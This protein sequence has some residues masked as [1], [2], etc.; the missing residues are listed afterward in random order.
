[1]RQKLKLLGGRLR[2]ARLGRK[3]PLRVIAGRVGVSI[4][5]LHEYENGSIEP[6][7]LRLFRL[8][9]VLNLSLNQLARETRRAA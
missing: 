6:P 7:A 2:G 1:M 4:A 5:T 8:A 3:L 9:Q